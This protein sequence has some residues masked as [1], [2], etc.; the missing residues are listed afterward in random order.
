MYLVQTFRLQGVRLF[1]IIS[2]FC[3]RALEKRLNSAK[4]TYDL[5]E[6]TS[7]SH[8]I[9][10]TVYSGKA[11]DYGVATIRRTGLLQKS[12]MTKET[13]LLQKSPMTKETHL[14][15]KSPMT[16]FYHR[17]LSF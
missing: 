10:V 14:L 1:K 2:L 12:P 15:Q 6:P 13:Y 16:I 3:K 7:R 8:P 11:A 9:E 4:E 17:G 5:K